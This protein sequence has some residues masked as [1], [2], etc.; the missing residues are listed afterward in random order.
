MEPEGK[1][2][3]PGND[4]HARTG[5]LKSNDRTEPATEQK[6]RIVL[7]H[8]AA[9]PLAG[10]VEHVLAHHVNLFQ[11]HGYQ[12]TIAAGRAAIGAPP[13]PC[14]VL[15]I[16]ELDSE[17]GTIQKITEA[18]N[19]DIVLPEFRTTQLAIEEALRP[20]CGAD[21]VLIG[22][23]V[24]SLHLNF[25]LTAAVHHLLDEH[26]LR[27]AVAWCH[28]VSRCV[29]PTSG[30]PLR[31]GFPWDLLRTFRPDVSYVAV[32]RQRQRVLSHVL[33]CSQDQIRVIPNG[34][35]PPAFAGVGDSISHLVEEYELF[36]ADLVLLLPARI[37]RAK[38]IKRALE[39]IASLKDMGLL[40]KLV[41]T[42]PPDPHKLDGTAYFKE[43]LA[44]RHKHNLEREVV[45]ALQGPN[46]FPGSPAIGSAEASELY[47]VCDLLLLTSN[48]EGFGIPILEAGLAGLP[49]FTTEVPA[50]EEFEPECV[51]LIERSELPSQ[52]A[53]RIKAWAESNPS[54]RLRRSIR[55]DY[56][57]SAIFRRHIE[58]LLH[59]CATL[60]TV[61]A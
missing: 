61:R 13:E 1:R 32:S 18:L 21:A 37:T 43:L 9:P 28:D 39:I 11:Q 53:R 42:G 17:N 54:L 50:L 10:G 25:P 48:R 19:S 46:A 20:V 60:D 22:H 23:N 34:I 5:K 29:N 4:W 44:L 56:T 52:V 41:V 2:P 6:P 27:A 30:V 45:F 57:W 35:D 33:G 51:N 47:R 59:E 24:L 58:P 36:Q 3:E 40:V 12:V 8:Y 38:N 14:E 49:I 26:S 55:R 7:L 15:V 16:P 31:F